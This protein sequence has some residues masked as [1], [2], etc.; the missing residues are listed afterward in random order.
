MNV[1]TRDI[2]G[3]MVVRVQGRLD[4]ATAPPLEMTCSEL[5]AAGACAAHVPRSGTVLLR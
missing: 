3:I 4:T 2:D 5:I 1:S